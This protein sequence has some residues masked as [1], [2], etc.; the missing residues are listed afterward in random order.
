MQ[1]PSAA[2]SGSPETQAPE[3]A[4]SGLR[5]IKAMHE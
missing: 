3:P 1:A 2:V 4:N 5:E